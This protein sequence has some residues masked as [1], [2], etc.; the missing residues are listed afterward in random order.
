MKNKKKDCAAKLF[1][2]LKLPLQPNWR[3][4]FLP[5]LDSE[6]TEQ[7]FAWSVSQD[8]STLMVTKHSVHITLFEGTLGGVMVSKV[9]KQTYRS[10][11][12]SH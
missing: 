5:E 4:K 2:K 11:F 8:L 7:S 10:E 6:H 1:D 12:D 3:L 9:D